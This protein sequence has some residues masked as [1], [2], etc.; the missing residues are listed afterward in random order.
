MQVEFH[1]RANSLFVSVCH[2]FDNAVSSVSRRNE[3]FRF[4]QLKKQYALTMEEELQ[5]IAKDILQKNKDEK[6][7]HEINQ[8]LHQVIREYLHRF[9]QKV[10]DL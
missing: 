10:N 7:V 8:M 9:I 1:K 5:T 4:Q 2:A 3:E 6:Q